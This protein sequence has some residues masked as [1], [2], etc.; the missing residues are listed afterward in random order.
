MWGSAGNFIKKYFANAGGKDN[1][2][3]HERNA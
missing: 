1:V 3:K 2:S